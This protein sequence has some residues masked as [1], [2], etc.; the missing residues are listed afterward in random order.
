MVESTRQVQSGDPS[1]RFN[2]ATDGPRLY[3]PYRFQRSKAQDLDSLQHDPVPLF[4][5]AQDPRYEATP[6]YT[7]GRSAKN[8][9][10]ASRIVTGL[11]ALS[12]AAGILALLSVDSTRAVIVNAKASLANVAPIPLGGAAPEATPQA[13]R[14]AAV[15]PASTEPASAPDAAGPP[16]TLASASPSR[17]EIAAAYQTAIKSRIVAVEPAARE[18]SPSARRI[19]PDE[20]AALLKRANGLL[21]IGDITAARL[22]LERAADAE[23]AEAALMLATTYDPLVVG[24]HDMRSITPDPA[25]ARLWY[26]KAAQLGSSDA[27]RRL[28][29]LQN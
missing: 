1:G 24:T 9:K 5:A 18:T 3:Q 14:F 21:A 7:F 23:A 15:Q 13:P 12:A 10:R 16:V 27:R 6:E 8:S 17:D 11:F 4:L 29:Q 2:E 28:S 22:L 25:S 19:D 20:L 26:Q